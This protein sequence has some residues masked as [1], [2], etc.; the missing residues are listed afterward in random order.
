MY[1]QSPNAYMHKEDFSDLSSKIRRIW[2]KIPTAMKA[3]I[4]RS[5][6]GNFND[7]ANNH[8]KNVYKTVKYSSCPTRKFT[9]AHLHELLIEIISEFSL[10]E[11]NELDTTKDEPCS[12]S[13]LLVN[14]TSTNAVSQGDIRKLMSTPDK[15]KA[16]SNKKQAAFSNEITL[17]GKT[18]RECVQHLIFY[19]TKS[20]CSSQ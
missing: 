11:Q 1:N 8:N 7:G 2:S 6:S 17:N 12:E 18:Y 3:I 4:F 10:S 9:A 16:T 14:S 15:S 19:L 5:K 20:S 13:K